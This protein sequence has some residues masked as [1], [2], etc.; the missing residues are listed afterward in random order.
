MRPTL[1]RS[2]SKSNDQ[3]AKADVHIHIMNIKRRWERSG[4]L[5]NEQNVPKVQ[6]VP[7]IKVA[8]V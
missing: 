1:S 3:G 6:K 2:S 4:D 7:G 5:F 8:G